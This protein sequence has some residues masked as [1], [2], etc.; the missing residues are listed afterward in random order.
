MCFAQ[1][2]VIKCQNYRHVV[3]KRGESENKTESQPII[4]ILF[5]FSNQNLHI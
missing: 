5:Y 4:S 2:G 3:K 1:L